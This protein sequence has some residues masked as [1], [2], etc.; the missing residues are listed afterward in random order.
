[1]ALRRGT[2]EVAMAYL[3][4]LYSKEGQEIIARHG[5]RPRDAEIAARYAGRFPQLKLLT[6]TDF[7]GWAQAQRTHFSDGGVFDQI[8]AR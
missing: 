6:I 3:G 4:Y 8:S 7:G 2:R 1:V 5:Y